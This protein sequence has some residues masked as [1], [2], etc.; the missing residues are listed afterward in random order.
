MFRT[1][2]SILNAFMLSSI[3]KFTKET[4][5]RMSE[6]KKRFFAE[7]GTSSVSG[8]NNPMYGKK[9]SQK[10]KNKISKSVKKTSIPEINYKR[11]NGVRGKKSK[12]KGTKLTEEHKKKISLNHS[13]SNLGKKFSKE[14]KDK[15]S[16]S[17][18]NGISSGKI[19]IRKGPKSKLWKG[20]NKSLACIIR[21]S[22]KYKKWRK[23]VFQRDNYTCQ[24]CG[25]NKGHIIEPHHIITLTSILNDLLKEFGKENFYTKIID[26]PKLYIISNG[27]TLCQTCHRKTETYGYNTNKKQV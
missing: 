22:A 16:K 25:Y 21:S 14:W 17:R 19:K 7:N 5:K 24:W 6:A 20:G 27:I 12:L 15:I 23:E 2:Y 26:N 11:G 13:K 3:M 9:H 4:R 18:I 10:T 1:S 8:K